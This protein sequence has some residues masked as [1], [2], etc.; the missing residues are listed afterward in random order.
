MASASDGEVALGL[1]QRRRRRPTRGAGRAAASTSTAWPRLL[2]AARSA[3]PKRISAAGRARV[4]A[5]LGE[6]VAAAVGVGELGGDVPGPVD[7]D[8]PVPAAGGP[9]HGQVAAAA[10][11]E[12]EV[13][14]RAA[15]AERTDELADQAL[16]LD[17]APSRRPR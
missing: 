16:A 13:E 7:V 2:L 5:E 9:E 14:A 15:A 10:L 12:L 8:D 3:A 6:Q 11:L 17:A 4:E 1:P